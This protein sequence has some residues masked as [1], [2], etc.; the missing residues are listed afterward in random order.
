MYEYIHRYIH[1]FVFIP[2]F[3]DSPALPNNDVKRAYDERE[4]CQCLPAHCGPQG[5]FQESI[6]QNA[7]RNLQQFRAE[8]ALLAATRW[9]P[10]HE[11][12]R[13][14]HAK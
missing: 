14:L 4:G 13:H 3:V 2:L 9:S 11:L 8:L 12:S 6:K 7:K 5:P 1:I 10:G